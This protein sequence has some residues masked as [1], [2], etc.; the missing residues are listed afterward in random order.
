MVPVSNLVS[1]RLAKKFKYFL[2]SHL[3][4]D[5]PTLEQGISQILLCLMQLN[6][7]FFYRSC[8]Y[9]AIDRNG[10]LLSDTICP[11]RCLL[12]Y[13]RIPPGVKM[14]HII[15]CSKVQ[16]QA[17]RFQANEKQRHITL[18]ELLNQVSSFLCCCCAVKIQ[19]FYFLLIQSFAYQCQMRSKLT[20]DK[21][22]MMV[23]MQIFYH[24]HK[25]FQFRRRNGQFLINQLCITSSLT[26]FGDFS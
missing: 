9:Q 16:A 14:Y 10:I 7:F 13:C 11:I 6:D 25:T 26:E 1:R 17:S 18:L 23:T 22:T 12:F 3:C 8:S 2:T 4:T 24:L 21:G 20:E 15:C 19:V 5:I